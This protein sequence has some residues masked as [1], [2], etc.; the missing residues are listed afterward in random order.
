MAHKWAD[1]PH[2]PSCLRG[3]QCSRASDRGTKSA[4]AYKWAEKL[5]N[6]CRLVTNASEPGTKAKVARNWATWPHSPYRLGGGGGGVPKALE[7]G[8]KSA[9]APK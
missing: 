9:L 4:M 5:H 1:C 3:P 6:L 2:N 8:T 7:R